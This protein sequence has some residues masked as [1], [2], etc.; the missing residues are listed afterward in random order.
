MRR[1]GSDYAY[2]PY[3][4]GNLN[5]NDQASRLQLRSWDSGRHE[6]AFIMKG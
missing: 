2:R 1:G 3:A 6:T 4:T 5:G